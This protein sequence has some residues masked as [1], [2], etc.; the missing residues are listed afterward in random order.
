MAEFF[1]D[2][3]IRRFLIQF[4]RI[5]SNWQ[6][7]YG[8]DSQGNNIY[9]RVPIQ[10][11]DSSRQA[12]TIIANNSA[13]NLPHAPMITY[14][15]SGLEYDQKRTQDPYFIEKLNVRQRYFNQET[16]EYENTQGDAFTVERMMPVPYTLRITVDMWTTNY[17][18][19]L[20][21]IEQLGV[22][23]NPSMEI[24]STD[25][26][27]DWTSL[28]VVYQ[29]GLSFTSRSIPVGTG[30]P[31]DILSWKF[32]MPIWISSAIKVKKLSIIYKVIA[33]IFKGNAISDMQDDDLLLGTRQKITA[34]GYK[35]LLVGNTLQVLPQDAV[36]QPANDNITPVAS[37]E[38]LAEAVGNTFFTKSPTSGIIS[39][40]AQATYIDTNPVVLAVTSEVVPNPG[41]V[42]GD[43]S[44]LDITNSSPTVITTTVEH[45]LQNG[46]A[47]MMTGILGMESPLGVGLNG[48]NYSV[49]VLST[50]NFELYKDSNL[51]DPLDTSDWSAYISGGTI[52]VG[53]AVVQLNNDATYNPITFEK[54]SVIDFMQPIS[55]NTSV[56]WPAVLNAYGNIRPGIS[57]IAL[58][59]P[60]LDHEI[61][62]TIVWNP[63]DERLLHYSID[64]DTLPQ[65]TMD[66]VNS[67]IDPQVKFPGDGLPPPID[68]Q[69]YLLINDIGS[70]AQV[71]FEI[72]EDYQPGT[73]V[74]K[75][76]FKPELASE[77]GP[78]PITGQPRITVTA[79]THANPVFKYY[80]SPTYITAIDAINSEITVSIPSMNIAN[81]GTVIQTS[82]ILNSAAWGNIVDPNGFEVAAVA[83]DII[84]W[85][86]NIQRWVRVFDSTQPTDIQFVTNLTTN[87]QYRWDG[88]AWMKSYEG[89]YPAGDWSVIL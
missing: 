64:P 62:G 53:V 58:D 66:A 4:A 31:I 67:V 44:V 83:N 9:M 72:T 84:Q 19:K 47:I 63:L 30:N 54:D 86:A 85:D 39:M 15:I 32:Y 8:K 75:C 11:G 13:S 7:T 33:S 71:F 52:N 74:F 89:F 78:D 59:N 69:R 81:V 70:S 25:N 51:F 26:F 68:G 3:Q 16:G 40:Q 35:V 79:G 20:E 61:L 24:Q 23:F 57:M 43:N 48:T 17:N 49:K 14:Y 73:T 37:V 55:P 21:L 1:Y 46:D 36:F 10:Y 50:T 12:A 22:L 42:G 65:N 87:I 34:Y 38:V 18:Q 5:F 88:N 29:D 80:P 28:S 56:Y 2:S 77:L 41:S 27:I 76:S 6:V 45:G 82:L 60:Y